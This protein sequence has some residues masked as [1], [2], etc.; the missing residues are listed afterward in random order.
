MF[1]HRLVKVMEKNMVTQKKEME[2]LDAEYTTKHHMEQRTLMKE[3]NYIMKKNDHIPEESDHITEE[4]D[5]ITEEINHILEEKFDEF[6][7]DYQ[8]PLILDE[9]VMDM[10]EKIMTVDQKS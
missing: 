9:D 3:N 10:E 8:I 4:T 1:S 2:D 6:S 7:D 5:Y